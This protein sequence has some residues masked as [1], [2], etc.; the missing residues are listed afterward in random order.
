MT[1]DLGAIVISFKETYTGQSREMP[2]LREGQKSAAR[3]R[4]GIVE[5]GA[6]AQRTASERA[7]WVRSASI[8]SA[9]AVGSNGVSSRTIQRRQASQYGFRERF[10]PKPVVIAT[11]NTNSKPKRAQFA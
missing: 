10:R 8:N 1:I 6:F 9:E 3:V 2:S 4:L 11:T 5:K 7:E